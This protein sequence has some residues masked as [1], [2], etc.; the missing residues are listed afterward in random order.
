MGQY[1]AMAVDGTNE[2]Y[3]KDQEVFL[4]KQHG[5]IEPGAFQPVLSFEN[6][7]PFMQ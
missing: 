6:A 1:P 3:F 5:V 4:T 2:S 7:T